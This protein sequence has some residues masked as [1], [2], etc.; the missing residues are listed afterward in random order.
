MN[1]F[2]VELQ[3]YIVGYCNAKNISIDLR[4]LCFGDKNEFYTSGEGLS[5]E[6]VEYYAK[7]EEDIKQF[8]ATYIDTMWENCNPPM[9]RIALY[10]ENIIDMDGWREVIVGGCPFTDE[11]LL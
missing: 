4:F 7:N 3:E 5:V 10:I 8:F 1:N 6:C 9:N 2:E 11:S